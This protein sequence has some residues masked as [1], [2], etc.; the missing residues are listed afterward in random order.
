MRLLDVIYAVKIPS[1]YSLRSFSPNLTRITKWWELR[2]VI[3]HYGSKFISDIEDSSNSGT[4]T[5]ELLQ[6]CTK[7]SAEAFMCLKSPQMRLFVERAGQANNKARHH[8]SLIRP[9][10]WLVTGG[11][12]SR[13]VS[14]VESISM[15]WRRFHANYAAYWQYWQFMTNSLFAREQ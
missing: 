13:R 2:F 3:V 9:I 11:F 5:M 6:S 8:L 10:S 4:L 7:P 12:P 1:L 15:P 14:N